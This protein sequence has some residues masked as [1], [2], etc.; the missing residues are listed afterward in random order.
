MEESHCNTERLQDITAGHSDQNGSR[1]PMNTCL[2]K[3]SL[4]HK[5]RCRHL[6]QPESIFKAP[7]SS[8]SA[9]IIYPLRSGHGFLQ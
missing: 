3:N 7:K 8:I 5:G 6:H 2:Y 9:M 1:Q 4:L